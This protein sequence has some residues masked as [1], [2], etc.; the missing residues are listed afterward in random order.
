[1]YQATKA[2]SRQ[3]S[4]RVINAY[5]ELA[6]PLLTVVRL[7]LAESELDELM[8]AFLGC[9]EGNHMTFHVAEIVPCVLI[10]AG[11]QTLF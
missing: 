1:M 8:V 9:G 6:Q 4:R 11:T 10:L 2:V 5:L 3:E 7:L